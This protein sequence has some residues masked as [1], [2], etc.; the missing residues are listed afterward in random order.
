MVTCRRPAYTR[1]SLRALIDSC[2]E[3]MRI[4]LWQNGSDPETL[5]VLDELAI[6]DQVHRY[7]HSRENVLLREPVNW[8]FDRARGEFLCLVNDDCLVVDGW[9]RTLRAAHRDVAEFGAVACWHFHE[10]DYIPELA[11]R[12]TRTFPGGRRLML[13]PWVQGS[14]VMVKRACIEEMGPLKE[15]ERG[16]TPYW[17]R[18]ARAGWLNGWH[19]PLVPHDHMDD[20]R[21]PHTMLKTDADLA[22]HL[23]LSARLRGVKTIEDWVAHLKL[24]ARAVQEAPVDPRHYV[25][26]RKKIRRLHTRVKREP[27]LY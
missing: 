11:E 2:D 22:Q 17:H 3:T 7:H 9:A 18:L 24:S 14:G 4:W 8:L 13:N 23:P 19:L 5:A 21:S 10:D 26:L 15:D 1:R 16:M 12:K 25:G 6:D 27:L 20:P